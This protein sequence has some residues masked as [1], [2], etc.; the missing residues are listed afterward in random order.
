MYIGD[1][2]LRVNTNGDCL[3][4]TEVCTLLSASL[5]GN[6]LAASTDV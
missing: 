1:W 4:L 2:F 5:V 3:D 6:I